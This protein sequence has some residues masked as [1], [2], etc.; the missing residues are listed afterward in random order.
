M[1]NSFNPYN[2]L[3]N[4]IKQ[5]IETLDSA[6]I[7]HLRNIGGGLD[8]FFS[9]WK[10]LVVVESLVILCVC[11]CFSADEAARWCVCHCLHDCGLVIYIYIYN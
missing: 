5:L 7:V 1:E 9:G 2:S 3:Q 6:Y 8:Y 10:I 11:I 4:H